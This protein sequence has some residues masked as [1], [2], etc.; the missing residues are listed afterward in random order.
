MNGSLTQK[1]RIIKNWEQNCRLF[2]NQFCLAICPDFFN[3]HCKWIHLATKLSSHCNYTYIK[4]SK[5]SFSKK[6]KISSVISWR[7]L[8]VRDDIV[9][10]NNPHVCMKYLLSSVYMCG[11]KTRSTQ[12]KNEN[13]LTHH[14]ALWGKIFHFV[15][16]QSKRFI[17]K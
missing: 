13:R 6:I 2:Q 10:R 11:G 1:V 4:K 15:Q 8:K 16:I 7:K 14:F 9:E 3:P 12:M 17:S 5:Q